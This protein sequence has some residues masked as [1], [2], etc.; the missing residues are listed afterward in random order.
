M[1]DEGIS[2]TG[3]IIHTP[4]EASAV[5]ARY[6][7][8]IERNR[9]RLCPILLPGMDDY[10]GAVLPGEIVMVQAQ[11]HNYKTGFMKSWAHRFANYL[12]ERGRDEIVIWIDTE[13]PMD[14]IALSQMARL[15]GETLPNIIYR[16][17]YDPKQML[18]AAR[19]ISKGKLFNIASTLGVDDVED[20]TLTNINNA[21]KMLVNGTFDGT[22]HKIAA[23]FI[24]YLQALPFD[25]AIKRQKDIDSQRR[26]Q[27]SQDVNT[28]RRMGSMYNAPVIL[29]VQA[30]QIMTGRLRTRATKYDKAEGLET[31]LEIPGFFDGQETSNIGQRADRILSL[32]MPKQQYSRGTQWTYRDHIW[33]VDDGLLV[34]QVHKQRLEGLASGDV[35]IYQIDHDAPSGDNMTFLWSSI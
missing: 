15:A 20:I 26:L 25:P 1:S 2:K 10:F 11:S 9:D 18:M 24:D 16:G 12:I 6:L 29:G 14:H 27:V 13:T 22:K 3:R 34:V 33:T 21:M 17:G 31:E 28:C 23:I 4:A 35:F 7:D 8:F 19:E 5:G 30:K 32:A